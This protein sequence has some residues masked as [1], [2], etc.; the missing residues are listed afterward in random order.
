MLSRPSPEQVLALKNSRIV[1]SCPSSD[2]F[3]EGLKNFHLRSYLPNQDNSIFI[4]PDYSACYFP[5]HKTAWSEHPQAMLAME[6]LCYSV[7]NRRMQV[8]RKR[9]NSLFFLVPETWTKALIE[10][11]RSEMDFL[12]NLE[13]TNPLRYP[14]RM[15]RADT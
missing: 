9:I 3:W 8:M 4:I 12:A 7:D 10:G 5:K 11:R 13:K 1:I 14:E 6:F 2:S 15:T